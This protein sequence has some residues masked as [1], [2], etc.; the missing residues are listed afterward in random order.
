MMINKRLI[1]T[2][3]ESEKY[4]AGNVVLQWCALVANIAMMTSITHLLQDLF[5]RTADAKSIVV[6]VLV[7]AIAVKIGRASCRERV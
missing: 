1:G 2:V 3:S 7:A 5:R 6:T 4:V